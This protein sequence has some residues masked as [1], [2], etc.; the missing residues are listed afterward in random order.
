MVNTDQTVTLFI[1]CLVDGI[2]PQVGE[3]VVGIFRK[4]GVNLTCP[5]RQTCCGQPA[6]NSGYQGE[7]RVAAKR[8]IEIFESAEAIVCPSGSCVTMV[9]HHYPQ[10]FAD[11]AAWLQRAQEVAAKTFE[12]TEYLVD[13]LGVVDDLGAHYTGVITYHDSCHLLRN[14]RIKEQPRSLLR[15]ISGAEFV[16]MNDS[17]RCCGFGGSFS[18]KYADISAAMAEDKVHNII[19]SG[20]DTVVG[21]DM[22]CLMNIQGMLSRQESSIR[23]MHIAELLA[24]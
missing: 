22:G 13:I 11:D 12:L 19:A 8:F 7:A 23:V 20:A 15:K 3:A 18:F 17:D 10:L 1:Q 9:R 6:F 21:C 4:L 14:L 24:S 5:T 2:Y 16:E